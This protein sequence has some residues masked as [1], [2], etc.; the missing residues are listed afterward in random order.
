MSH[1]LRLTSPLAMSLWHV[2]RAGV[3]GVSLLLVD[4]ANLLEAW[5]LVERFTDAARV[6]R[7]RLRCTD[8]GH[9][10]ATVLIAPKG[11]T[12]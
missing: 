8:Y 6:F 7:E 3:T 11:T 9:R 10:V 5:G 2:H 4:D 1:A 12:A